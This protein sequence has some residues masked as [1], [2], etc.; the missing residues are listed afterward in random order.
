MTLLSTIQLAKNSLFTSQLGIQ[1][2]S[3]NIANADTP[4]YVREK[5]LLTTAPSQQMG[6]LTLGSGVMS[7]GVVREVDQFLQQRLWSASSDLGNGQ[8]QQQTY[9]QLEAAIGEFSDVDL[10]SSLA[11]F[12][13]SIN[14][15]LNQPEDP[16]VRS[17]AV[18]RGE[19]LTDQIRHLDGRI[20][21][22][23]ETTNNR[24]RDAA[25]EINRLVQQVSQLN[26]QV[27]EMEMGGASG[28]DAVG[29]RDKRDQALAEL[30]R[31]IDIKVDEQPTGAVNVFAGGDYLVFDGAVQMVKIETQG[32][33]GLATVELLLA[34]SEAPVPS[35]SGE[36]AGLIASRDQILGGFLDNLDG[37]VGSLIHGFNKL[38][39]SGQ[40]L[41]GYQEVTGEYVVTDT[42]APLDEAGLAFTPEHGSFVVEVYS[43]ETG[44]RQR[45][46]IH[47]KLNGLEDDTTLSSLAADLNAI[48]GLAADIT[49]DGRLRLRSESADLQFGF[50]EDSSGTLAALGVNTFF[51]GDSAYNIHVHEL[52]ANDA[53][54]FAA[55]RGGIGLDTGNAEALASFLNEPLESRNGSSLAQVYD[56]WIGEVA[57]SASLSQ[58]V[59]DGFRAF[60]TTLE[61]EHL[62]LTGV[63]L[64]EEAVNMITFQR[65]FQASARLIT[66]ISEMLDVLVNL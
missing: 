45:H 61:G 59:A 18:T 2:A 46:D 49:V 31:I 66:T 14:D 33:R 19:A 3:Q 51:T 16:S 44:L 28:S 15:V 24:I 38:H 7:I 42:D 39:A 58:A 34:N 50:A 54:M 65:T 4:G 25:S 11:Q 13:N 29:L 17:L 57:Q 60:H 1:V 21:D 35:S 12:F 20:R 8:V 43:P 64:D 26:V 63:S 9:A 36:L 41:A 22:L 55:S 53:R 47:V 5:L 37:F 32:N 30:A 23:R 40:G 27:M 6:Q 56:G 10:S 48:D 52:V 62:G